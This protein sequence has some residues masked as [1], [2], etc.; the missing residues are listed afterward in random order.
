MYIPLS[1]IAGAKPKRANIT[2]KITFL[3]RIKLIYLFKVYINK[4]NYYFNFFNY[5]LTRA[6]I[7]K[8]M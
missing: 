2:T 3:K 5:L 4:R 1:N 6:I 8:S 7:V